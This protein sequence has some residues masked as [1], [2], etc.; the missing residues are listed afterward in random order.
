[1]VLK[2]NL[3]A[4]LALTGVA[5][6]ATP[7][8]I[9]SRSTNNNGGLLKLLDANGNTLQ[10]RGSPKYLQINLG[11]RPGA[12][13]VPDGSVYS[14]N[15]LSVHALSKNPDSERSEPCKGKITFQ[16]PVE[17][18]G[19]VNLDDCLTEPGSKFGIGLFLRTPTGDAKELASLDYEQKIPERV[20]VIDFVRLQVPV[21]SPAPTQVKGKEEQVIVI[22]QSENN[23]NNDIVVNRKI[24]PLLFLYTFGGKLTFGRYDVSRST[25]PN[26]RFGLFRYDLNL[27][28]G[29]GTN[30]VSLMVT[31]GFDD[32][33]SL[34]GVYKP[35]GETLSFKPSDRR[36]G[37]AGLRLAVNAG[38]GRT[39][40]RLM[41]HGN[42]LFQKLNF[43][44]LGQL[45]QET[46][47]GGRV[48]ADIEVP[49]LIWNGNRF[50]WGLEAHGDLEVLGIKQVIPG[51]T[52]DYGVKHRLHLY[53][54]TVMKGNAKYASVSFRAGAGFDSMLHLDFN[55]ELSPDRLRQLDAQVKSGNAYVGD[56]TR[57][58]TISPFGLARLNVQ[59][60]SSKVVNN[61]AV[62]GIFPLDTTNEV[63]RYMA[64]LEYGVNFSK[65]AKLNFNL[66]YSGGKNGAVRSDAGTVSLGFGD[67]TPLQH[68]IDWLDIR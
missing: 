34:D 24:N 67:T 9:L 23:G 37:Q 10:D 1:M 13:S 63:Q 21:P 39:N 54:D 5:N 45:M 3:L 6:A 38:S 31:A 2:K 48:V 66:C 55:E 53:G 64:C 52:T 26:I 7:E 40:T 42:G 4:S 18:T 35:T 22:P 25:D 46:A 56:L 30:N 62:S 61:F 51:L 17:T 19:K 49:K 16:Y 60:Y 14:L 27:G 47:N 50:V 8:E 12:L 29:A 65:M 68:R 57:P 11:D 43:N 28:L 32:I 44:Y 15:D 41:L 33:V 58:N 59:P 36:V 20:T